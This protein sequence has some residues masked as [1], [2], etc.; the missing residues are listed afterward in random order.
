MPTR[1]VLTDTR[2]L[3]C[4]C[5]ETQACAGGCGW[6]L[7]SRAK[8]WGVCSRCESQIPELMNRLGHWLLRRHDR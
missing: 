7:R 5:T 4:G 8:D 3:F 1:S 2:C 6:V